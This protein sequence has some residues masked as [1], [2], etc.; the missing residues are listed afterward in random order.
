MK[1]TIMLFALII[2]TM[3]ALS[4]CGKKGCTDAVATNY[5]EKCKKDDGSCTYKGAVQ[6]WYKKATSDS[7]IADGSTSLTF[8][9]DGAVIGSY[10]ATVYF[11][12]DPACGQASVVRSEKDLGTSKSKT[13]TY[14]V[15]DQTGFEVWSG[16]VTYDGTKSCTSYELT[17]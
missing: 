16:S 6:F 13:S 8:Y 7:L 3:L 11:T 12:G 10:A 1:K 2:G 15:K 14:S 9:V 17:N 5:C 4:S